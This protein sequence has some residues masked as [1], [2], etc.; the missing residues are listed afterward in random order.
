MAHKPRRKS[1]F[2][3]ILC[4]FGKHKRDATMARKRNGVWYTVCTGCDLDMLKR[5]DGAG[6][7]VLRHQQRRRRSHRSGRPSV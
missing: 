7:I 3:K 2:R 4:L 5:D 6:W 1:I